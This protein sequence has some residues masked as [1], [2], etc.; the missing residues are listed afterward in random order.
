MLAFLSAEDKIYSPSQIDSVISVEI[1]DV[2][3]DPQCYDVVSRLM[4][5]GPCGHLFPNS[6][7]M[8]A[9]KCTKHY[10]KKYYP[11]TTIDED[12]FRRYKHRED[13]RTIEKSGVHLDNRYV[14]P[15]NQYLL[16]RFDAHINVEFYNKSRLVQAA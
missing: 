13:G 1:P 5:H 8:V 12:G 16:F 14:V 10:P 2:I 3:A 7:C 11:E 4:L 15:Y 6:P 9:E